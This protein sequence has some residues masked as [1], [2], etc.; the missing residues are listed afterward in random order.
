VITRAA[1]SRVRFRN[2]TVKE[3]RDYIES[4]EWDGK[5]GAYAI[6]GLAGAFVAE[7]DGDYNNVVGLPIQLIHDLLRQ[8]FVHCRFR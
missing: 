4:R 1:V 7:L 5:A 3:I 6:Q 2:L 8:D